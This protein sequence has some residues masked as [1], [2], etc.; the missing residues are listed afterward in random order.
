M[1][2]LLTRRSPF[3]TRLPIHH[4]NVIDYRQKVI[5]STVPSVLLLF[6]TV[7]WRSRVWVYTLS[8]YLFVLHQFRTTSH[9]PPDLLFTRSRAPVPNTTTSLRINSRKEEDCSIFPLM[10]RTHDNA[11]FLRPYGRRSTSHRSPILIDTPLHRST[12]LTLTWP[13]VD[14]YNRSGL[15]PSGDTRSVDLTIGCLSSMEVE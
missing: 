1:T 13:I 7:S 6:S 12:L 4:L 9:F 14:S 11:P 15:C 2:D 5:T 8:G 10:G 3:T